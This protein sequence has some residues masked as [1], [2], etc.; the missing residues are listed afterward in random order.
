MT[1]NARPLE[2]IREQEGGGGT[3]ARLFI[4]AGSENNKNKQLRTREG[5]GMRIRRWWRMQF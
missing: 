2:F 4:R 1:R 5:G 3:D